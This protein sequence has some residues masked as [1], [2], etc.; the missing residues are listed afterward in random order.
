MDRVYVTL[1]GLFIAVFLILNA[2]NAEVA[3]YIIH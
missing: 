2:V 1:N 3:K